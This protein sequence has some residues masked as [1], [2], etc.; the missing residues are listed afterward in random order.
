MALLDRIKQMKIQGLTEK[1]IASE[2]QNEGVNPRE[3]QEGLVHLGIKEA[4]D[5]ENQSIMR[6][7]EEEFIPPSPNN[8]GAYSPS[9]YEMPPI[10]QESYFAP[11]EQ[12]Q[13]RGQEYYPQENY[14]GGETGTS[15]GTEMIMEIAQQ[16][17]EEKIK[18]IENLLVSLKEFSIIAESKLSSFEERI[19]KIENVMDNLQIKI[20]EKIGSYGYGIEGIKKE[21][22]MMQDSF[23][24][25][26][27]EMVKKQEKINDKKISE[28]KKIRK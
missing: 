14:A 2:L 18:K 8:S 23:S 13:A 27:P 10:Q 6:T 15:V 7:Q 3:I 11:Q 26:I 5:G 22:E 9:S 1:E 25:M 24:K 28:K 20:L 16:V 19:K 21:M 17:F 12:T 4:V